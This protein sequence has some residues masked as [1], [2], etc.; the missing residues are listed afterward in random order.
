MRILKPVRPLGQVLN[1]V[2]GGMKGDASGRTGWVAPDDCQAEFWYSRDRARRATDEEKASQA[3]N[4]SQL[5]EGGDGE[6]VICTI[7]ERVGE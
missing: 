2:D 5:V 4:M 6:D 3:T 1:D 7:K